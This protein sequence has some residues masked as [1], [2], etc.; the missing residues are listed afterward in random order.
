MVHRPIPELTILVP[1][2][3]PHG[4]I[5]LQ[6]Q[7][8]VSAGCDGLGVCRHGTGRHPVVCV[9][10]PGLRLGLGLGLEF[11]FWFFKG[12]RVRVRFRRRVKVGVKV[13]VG[14]CGLK[15]SVNS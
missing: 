1:T 9:Y 8:V 2:R 13:K 15:Y 5:A 7:A 4:T 14:Y 10:T 12:F 3:A 11:G 6:H